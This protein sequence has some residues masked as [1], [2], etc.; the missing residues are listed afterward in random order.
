ML[1]LT[2]KRTKPVTQS[3]QSRLVS[4]TGPAVSSCTYFEPI[5]AGRFRVC[6]HCYRSSCTQSS[7]ERGTRNGVV[8]ASTSIEGG[9]EHKH[10]PLT[11]H[12]VGHCALGR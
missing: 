5:Q 6:Q 10:T 8:V 7:G 1:L 4:H 9:P 12:T 3:A 11:R 2:Q